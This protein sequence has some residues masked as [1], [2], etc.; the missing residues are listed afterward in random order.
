[1]RV[2]AALEQWAAE[3]TEQLSAETL[4]EVAKI[5]EIVRDSS[6]A[7]TAITDVGDDF[8]IQLD[9]V[10]APDRAERAK[11]LI[12]VVS[13]WLAKQDAV[14]AEPI[15]EPLV[16][17]T[18]PEPA[19]EPELS[20]TPLLAAQPLPQADMADAEVAAPAF[21]NSD[22]IDEEDDARLYGPKRPWKA[23]LGTFVALAL[24]AGAGLAG[25]W[26]F[27]QR[28]TT[29][30]TNTAAPAE[31]SAT[32]VPVTEGDTELA[33]PTEVPT[34]VPAPEPTPDL[35]TFWAET[36]P[37]LNSGAA[38]ISASTY[39]VSP[40]NRAVLTGHTAAIT[41]VVVSD[42]GRVLTS[43]ADR[44][45]VDWGADVTLANPDVLNVPSPLTVLERTVDQRII[46]GDADG[47]ITVID[48]VTTAEPIVVAVHDVAISAAAELSDGRIAVASADGDVDVFAIETPE[49]RM[50]LPHPV[51]VTAVVA[52][53]DGRIA[54][55]AVDST[56]RIWPP[57]GTDS[58]VAIQSLAGPAT[59]L[60]ALDDGSLAM[61]SVNGELQVVSLD[62]DTA[63]QVVELAGHIGAIRALFETALPDGT[64]VLASG[65]DDT[66]IRL[67]DLATQSQLRVLEGHG[68]II[69]GI[70]ALPDRRLVT[71]SG[72][73]TGRVWDLSVPP[74]RTVLAPHDWNVSAIEPWNND[75][76]ITGG[77]DGKIV[78]ASTA[79][80]TEPIVLTQHGAPIVGAGRL[81]NGDVLSLDASSVARVSRV[82]A[83]ANSPFEFSV[84]PGATS[85]DVRESFG[86]V[87]G[88]ADGSV[89][90]YDFVS[91][92]A[93]DSEDTTSDES[94]APDQ[95][96]PGDPGVSIAESAAVEAH[97]SGV[98]DVVRLSSGLVASAGQDM[99][100]RITDFENPD[101]V[102]VFDLHTAPVDVVIELPDGRIASAGS[103]GIYIYTVEGL[104]QDHIRLNGQRS[105]TISLVALA[106]DRLVSTGDDGRVRLW[107]LTSPESEPTTLVD[108]PGVV[109]PHLI[110]ADNGLFVA[111]AARGYV[112]FTLS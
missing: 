100:V 65:G 92:T 38:E 77:I 32:A 39:S 69:S 29:A 41:G 104:A 101:Q 88:H 54:T 5:A 94:A 108:I 34:E 79:P 11:T 58:P 60:V 20:S 12:D 72:D 59:A 28:D 1:M 8:R 15:D 98:N 46:A 106:N 30:D 51:E 52:L 89:R 3:H 105:R 35:P 27:T 7:D 80:G 22:R 31:A 2:A 9:D 90:S 87:T 93:P 48:L 14:K 81:A 68:D 57:D 70:D 82:S 56:I 47:N 97:G 49:D 111:G 43:G 67:W 44:R 16:Q 84:A 91:D 63:T 19:A 95:A 110:L 66:T 103:D 55:A 83:T 75:Q 50:S 13:G 85:L 45:L 24:V 25:W 107:D 33:V 76:F 62:G 102:L 109:N 36:T 21:L 10:F 61:A 112:V 71:T 73:G 18:A 17:I 64:A 74:N 78:V 99:T 23:I 96:V 37:I 4:G 53:A 40:S 42:D 86:I 26:W 6:L